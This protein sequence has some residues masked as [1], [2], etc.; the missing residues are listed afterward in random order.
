MIRR[1]PRST[2]TDTLFP[3]TTLFRSLAYRADRREKDQR[4]DQSI[5]DG[6]CGPGRPHQ[7]A[8]VAHC[9][10]PAEVIGPEAVEF[11]TGRLMILLVTPPIIPRKTVSSW[12][13]RRSLTAMAGCSCSG[14]IGRAHV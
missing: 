2:R 10:T 14:E 7:P 4:Q 5:F 12:S 11:R 13:L 9:S 1:P 8:N 6:R 3:Y